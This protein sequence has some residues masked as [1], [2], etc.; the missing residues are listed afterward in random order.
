MGVFSCT[1]SEGPSAQQRGQ[2]AA[3]SGAS[4]TQCQ[5]HQRPLR[6]R[7]AGSWGTPK[8]HSTP[9]AD[10][11][12]LIGEVPA[13]S[14]LKQPGNFKVSQHG[15]FLP[16][17]DVSSRARRAR[18]PRPQPQPPMEGTPFSA[19]LAWLSQHRAWALAPLL[20]KPTWPLPAMHTAP[21]HRR[22]LPWDQVQQPSHH[23]TH[24]HSSLSTVSP[25][26]M[27]QLCY[28]NFHLFSPQNPITKSPVSVIFTGGH[29]TVILGYREEGP[30][31]PALALPQLSL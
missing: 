20:Q 17:L 13:I 22:L 9:A 14:Y 15:L 26:H 28:K 25:A 3:G 21:T 12:R 18:E 19:P 5:G 24:E 7:K 8:W 30:E 31:R 23:Q 29:S 1:H 6:S 2:E 27:L 16:A 10:V 4:G 11:S